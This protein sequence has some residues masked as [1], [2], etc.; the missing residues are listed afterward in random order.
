MEK[1]THV[2]AVFSFMIYLFE[3]DLTTVEISESF[4]GGGDLCAPSATP[5]VCTVPSSPS[6]DFSPSHLLVSTS[7]GTGTRC[8]NSVLSQ[9]E[10][11]LLYC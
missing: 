5:Q 3:M 6:S 1:K 9:Q 4:R 8:L 11:S 2:G 7:L 10:Q